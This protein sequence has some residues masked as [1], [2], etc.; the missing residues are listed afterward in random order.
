[1]AASDATSERVRLAR[2]LAYYLRETA[3]PRLANTAVEAIQTAAIQSTGG[4]MRRGKQVRPGDA[5]SPI[6]LTS[7]RRAWAHKLRCAQMA[8]LAEIAL[9]RFHAEQRQGAESPAE[10][11]AAKI[12]ERIE[13]ALTRA[14]S[15]DEP[16]A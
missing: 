5:S 7:E 9:E 1:M 14:G 12:G 15:V 13:D 4:R 10:A 8:E 3:V 6:E 11:Q 2:S 16:V